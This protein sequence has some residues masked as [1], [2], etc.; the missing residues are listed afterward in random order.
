MQLKDL[1]EGDIIVS[2]STFPCLQEG[3][4]KVFRDNSKAF[5]EDFSRLYVKCEEG[6]HFLD[7]TIDL[8]NDNQLMGWSK[9]S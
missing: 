8:E 6:K 3:K 7:G 2:D 5:P 4:Y 1:K 9:E